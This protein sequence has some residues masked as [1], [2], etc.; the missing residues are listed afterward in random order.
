[1]PLIKLETSVDLSG[2]QT[3]KLLSDL[4][5]TVA[6][7]T[8][9]PETY[10]MAIVQKADIM[11]GG[12]SGPAAFADIRGIGGLDPDTN[13][14]LSAALCELISDSIAVANDK[15]YLNFTDVAASNW[16]WNNGTF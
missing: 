2:E 7:V 14:K 4:S 3:E 15:I 8:G 11:L 13:N 6:D 9:K 10:V 12:E 5:R 16:G 1:M